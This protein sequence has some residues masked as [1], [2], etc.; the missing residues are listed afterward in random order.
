[1]TLTG[2]YKERSPLGFPAFWSYSLVP[3]VLRFSLFRPVLLSCTRTASPPDQS[4]NAPARVNET[5]QSTPWRH[6]DMPGREASIKSNTS[7]NADVMEIIWNLLNK[8]THGLKQM[9][10]KIVLI[11]WIHSAEYCCVYVCVFALTSLISI[12]FYKKKLNGY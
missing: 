9:T 1:M 6:H 3:Q 10:R 8:S 11:D 7:D 5:G 2:F 12:I 4:W